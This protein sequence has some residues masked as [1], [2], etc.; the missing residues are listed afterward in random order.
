MATY[1]KLPLSGGMAGGGPYAHNS[2]WG[3]TQVHATSSTA[4]VMDEVWLWAVNTSSSDFN[5]TVTIGGISL[6]YVL[7]P[8]STQLIY[9][10]ILLF[11]EAG[12]PTTMVVEAVSSG[13]FFTYG[14]VNRITP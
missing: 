3:P 9:P 12:T 8:N 1:T 7:P 5:M 4:N 14:Y 2:I 11:P 10:G 13:D 6:A